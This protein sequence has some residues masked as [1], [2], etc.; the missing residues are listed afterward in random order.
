VRRKTFHATGLLA[1]T[2]AIHHRLQPPGIQLVFPCDRE[3]LSRQLLPF[4]RSK[5]RAFGPFRSRS[6]LVRG[7][8]LAGDLPLVYP[9]NKEAS[10]EEGK[11]VFGT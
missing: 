3:H 4:S 11:G 1:H 5:N 10:N 8:C 7:W 6:K 9:A 2:L